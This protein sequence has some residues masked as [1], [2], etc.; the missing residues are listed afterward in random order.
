MVTAIFISIMEHFDIVIV[1]AGLHGLAAARILAHSSPTRPQHRL[2]ILD[3]GRSIGGTWAGERLYDGLKTNNVVG[4]YEFSDFPMDLERYG[5]EPGQHIP[6][7]VVHAYFRDFATH[8]GLDRL[9]RQ[10]TRVETAS[11]QANGT[12]ELACTSLC[13]GERGRRDVKLTCD[14]LVVATGLTSEARMPTFPGSS[15]FLGPLFHAKDLHGRSRDLERCEEVVV[16][17]GNKSAW[18]ACYSVASRGARAH[19]VIRRSGGGPSWVWRPFY[20]FGTRL[21]LARLS[22]TRLCSWF[23]PSPFGS[24]FSSIRRFLHGTVLGT[25]LVWAFWALLDFFAAAATGY[26]DPGLAMLR[27]WTSTFWM[28]NSLSIH[29]YETDWFELVR[30]GRI[31]VHHA[32]VASLER[33]TVCLS[34]GNSLRADAVVCCTGWECMPSI[35]FEPEGIP[36][37]IGL[38]RE[39]KSRKQDRATASQKGS[40]QR[41]PEPTSSKREPRDQREQETRSWARAQ[42]RAQ[43]AQLGFSPRR[44][45][46]RDDG[47]SRTGWDLSL[48]PHTNKPLALDAREAPYRLYRFLVPASPR[49][50]GLRNIAFIG[51]HR[52]V[53]AAIVAQAQALWVS[54]YFERRLAVDPEEEPAAAYREATWHAEYERLR[55]PRESGGSGASFPDLVFD[56]IPYTDLL[57][58]DLG[59]RTMRK[60]TLWA[61]IAR[62][63]LPADYKYVFFSSRAC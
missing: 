5:L 61:D 8:F 53:H 40:D 41:Q 24:S 36:E 10:Q 57:L 60:R 7:S 12:W 21:T 46:P 62:P 2:V 35:R 1:G 50:A 42:I 33:T 43:C 51:M 18:D 48:R 34:N 30:K 29:N 23:D 44:T 49:F 28:G 11:L 63:Y 4:S 55:R 26:R 25:W 9:I 32:E 16:V 59:L 54:A 20:V 6:G 56:S 17:G 27:P 45:L 52:S 13:E 37:E 47:T 39:V 15:D 22:A 14:K 38:P 3:E 58:E 19:M 31:I